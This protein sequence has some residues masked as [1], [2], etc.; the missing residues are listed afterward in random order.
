MGIIKPTADQ[1]MKYFKSNH[2]NRTE[3]IAE[4]FGST[5]G[6]ISYVIDENLS[7]KK[8]YM[9]RPITKFTNKYKIKRK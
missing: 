5:K 6:Y 4:Y 7:K 2:D 9:G 8:H 3:V 1:V